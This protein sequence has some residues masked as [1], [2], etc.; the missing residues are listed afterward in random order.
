MKSPAG[1]ETA[2]MIEGG[3]EN[4]ATDMQ[5]LGKHQEFKARKYIYAGSGTGCGR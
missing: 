5:R 3:T 1:V 4:D 2:E